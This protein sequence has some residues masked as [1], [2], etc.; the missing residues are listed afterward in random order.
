M[1]DNITDADIQE[2]LGEDTLADLLGETTTETSGDSILSLIESMDFDESNEDTMDSLTEELDA[3]IAEFTVEEFPAD[4][5]LTEKTGMKLDKAA[6]LKKAVSLKAM[7]IAKKENP[8][9][10]AKWQKANEVEKKMT[11]LI[12]KKYKAKAIKAVKAGK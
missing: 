9:M 7:S 5:T 3:A 4:D 12:I 11:A 8:G 10:Y 1:N 6:K 2:L